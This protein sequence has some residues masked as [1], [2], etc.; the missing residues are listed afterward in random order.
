MQDSWSEDSN[1][2]IQEKRINLQLYTKE[3]LQMY[4]LWDSLDWKL[5]NHHIVIL[6]IWISHYMVELEC[7]TI[8]SK[9]FKDKLRKL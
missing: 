5:D 3:E 2:N 6:V 7:H 8:I 9:W 1:L 4:G